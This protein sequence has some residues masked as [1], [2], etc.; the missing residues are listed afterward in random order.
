MRATTILAM[1]TVTL[2]SGPWV[3]GGEK[4]E[5]GQE[6]R[7]HRSPSA[8]GSWPEQWGERKLYRAEL[9]LVYARKKATADEALRM[10][11]EVVGEARQDG[12]LKPALGLI[13]VVDAQEKS[14][15]ALAKLTEILNDP[16]T[17]VDEESSKEVLN[18]LK[19][20][21]KLSDQ[22]GTDMNSLV[23]VLP[24]AFR[25]AALP[26]IGREFPAGLDREIAWCLL[27]PTDKYVGASLRA[28]MDAMVKIDNMNW[29]ERL[30][31]G[32]MMP[33][34]QRKGEAEMR[35]IRRACLYQLLLDSQ[36][37]LSPEARR[38]K[39]RAYRQRLGLDNSEPQAGQQ[40]KEER[41]EGNQVLDNR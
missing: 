9:A 37:D 31:I 24:I 33:L 23:A 3:P 4:R 35:K 19:E 8:T 34:A 21:R 39:V 27:V 15:L 30:L 22:A 38:E 12:A 28:M 32:A 40:G 26:K 11:R 25:P 1:A 36:T 10:L 17:R 7:T 16:N 2:A 6:Q 41:P 14:P 13:V 20:A 29:K 5:S 18:A